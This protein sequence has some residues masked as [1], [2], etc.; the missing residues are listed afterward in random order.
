M[1]TNAPALFV[2]HLKNIKD[3]VSRFERILD[4]YL[5]LRTLAALH[6]VVQEL[7]QRSSVEGMKV[8]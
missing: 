2:N 7:F 6:A 1:S 4:S 3:F 8:N 5:Q